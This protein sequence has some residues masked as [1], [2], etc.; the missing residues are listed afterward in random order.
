MEPRN[1]DQ[2]GGCGASRVLQLRH[3]HMD[4]RDGISDRPDPYSYDD[5]FSFYP[6][7]AA[8][9]NSHGRF[10]ICACR[11]AKLLLAAHES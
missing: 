11:L 9:R 4:K 10:A 6:S 2:R 8:R 1:R 7:V 5:G 3:F